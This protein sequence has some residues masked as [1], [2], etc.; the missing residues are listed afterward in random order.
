MEKEIAFTEAQHWFDSQTKRVRE[1]SSTLERLRAAKKKKPKKNQP[2]EGG[3]NPTAG[4]IRR[5]KLSEMRHLITSENEQIERMSIN[6]SF[7][8]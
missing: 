7:L 1:A 3:G 5:K 8:A 6:L 4:E 2:G